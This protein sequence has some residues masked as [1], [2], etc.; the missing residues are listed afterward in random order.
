MTNSRRLPPASRRRGRRWLAGLLTVS[1]GTLLVLATP[2]GALPTA[3]RGD[4]LTAAEFEGAGPGNDVV[5][6]SAPIDAAMP[7]S[8]QPHG[9]WSG[10]VRMFA[11]DDGDAEVSL[12]DPTGRGDGPYGAIPLEVDGTD[13]REPRAVTLSLGRTSVAEDAGTT[14]VEVTATLGASA[15][16]ATDITVAVTGDTADEGSDFSAVPDFTLTVAANSTSGTASFDITPTDD[17]LVEGDERL[18]VGGSGT[19]LEVTAATLT[20]TDDD[21]ATLSV[22][23]DSAAIAE[24][25]QDAA[26]VTVAITNGV[27][28][29]HAQDIAVTLGGTAAAGRDY[30]FTD[31]A[32]RTFTRPYI[33]VLPAQASSVSGAITAIDDD[34]DDDAET[35]TL[36]VAHSG[37]AFGGTQTI[38]ITDDDDAPALELSGLTLS[39]TNTRQAYPDFDADTLHYGVGCSS[40][41]TVEVTPTA[42]GPDVRISVAGRQTT[43]GTAVALS[44]P[45]SDSVVEVVLSNSGGESRTYTIHCVPHDFPRIAVQRVSGAWDGLFL[46]SVNLGNR[47]DP[48]NRWSFLVV[49]DTNGV[50]RFL[51]KLPAHHAAHFR[52]QEGG[53]YPYGYLRTPNNVL[54]LL[55]RDL[56]E[57]RTTTSSTWSEAGAGWADSHLDVHDFL[58]K[59]DGTSVIVIDDPVTRDL[60]SI[61]FGSFG[62]AESMKDERIIEVTRGGSVT[63]VWDSWE[64]LEV[65]DCTQQ[66]FTGDGAYSHFNSIELLADGHYL[67]S[68]KGCSQIVKIDS[69]TGATLWQVGRTNLSAAEWTANGRTAPYAI[70]GDPHGEF[71]GQHSAKLIGNGNLLLY[72]NGNECLEDPETG[73]VASGIVRHNHDFSRVVEYTLDHERRVA[74]FLRQHSLGGAQNAATP[75]TGLVAPTDSGNWWI[76]WGGGIDPDATQSITEVDPDTKAEVLHILFSDARSNRV[77]TRSYPIREDEFRLDPPPLT[78]R[79]V[80]APSRYYPADSE[81]ARVV[82]AFN[83]PVV[84]FATST[85]SVSVTGATLDDVSPLVEAGQPANAYVF[86][87][88]GAGD[89]IGFS[90]LP[91]Q[92]CASGAVCTLDGALLEDV[93]SA[94]VV[95]AEHARSSPARRPRAASPR[96]ARPARGLEAP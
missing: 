13:A 73:S 75:Y 23:V 47:S 58:N 7:G 42:T 53:H 60:S 89:D 70:E 92:G 95:A 12:H 78:A 40:G 31:A 74:R 48:N 76:S 83:R 33:L 18:T 4:P 55:D 65:R 35:V 22:S 52:P 25:V 5:R 71:C 68:L 64:R 80:E 11:I 41:D 66:N 63:E 32:G 54:V 67:V 94:A 45:E 15:D 49:M 37:A 62:T 28:F 14:S 82:V 8:E 96:T 81:R 51:R 6:W 61:G 34:R 38:T 29:Q 43:S 27:T 86:T 17:S 39:T 20:L 44:D 46:G 36:A 24:S 9:L 79:I 88:T 87:V 57:A 84:D 90:L 30:T 91:G 56:D 93:P 16:T 2:D 10:G 3:A 72:D 77:T 21:S 85:P 26:T 59:P 19:D 1:T 50:P 69:N